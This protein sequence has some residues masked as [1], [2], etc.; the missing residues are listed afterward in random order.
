MTDTHHMPTPADPVHTENF[1][2][3]FQP[4]VTMLRPY[5]LVSM[6]SVSS[7]RQ[8]LISKAFPPDNIF[9]RDR[10]GGGS[11]AGADRREGVGERSR[12][13]RRWRK[14]GLV[15]PDL[16]KAAV[17]VISYLNLQ[18]RQAVTGKFRQSKID[19]HHALNQARCIARVQNF[20]ATI[21]RDW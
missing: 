3:R 4:N 8:S 13:D 1:I 16:R 20:G 6:F 14:A 10:G 19:L 11:S 2:Q 7:S 9:G 18:G 17:P 5:R 15:N 12:G 21:D